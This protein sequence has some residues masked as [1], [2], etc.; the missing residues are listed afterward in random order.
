[1]KSNLGALR[2]L[3]I[4]T[5]LLLVCIPLAAQQ[6]QSQPA[7]RP[8]KIEGD[9]LIRYDNISSLTGSGN[10]DR[11]RAWLRPGFHLAPASW[12]RLEARG[13]FA[14]GT[15]GNRQS[16]LRFDNFHSH[17]ASVDRLYL[18]VK[19]RGFEFGAGKFAMPLQV[20]EMI[21]DHD[22]QPSGLY[23]G[24]RRAGISLTGGVFY[25]SH[26]H[27]DRST[28]AGGQ[29]AFRHN[30]QG[31]WT[32]LATAG[33]M[34]FNALEQFQ[35]GMARQ[36][37]TM[38]EGGRLRYQSDFE[39]ANGQFRIEHHG[40]A[41]WPLAI[42]STL[43]YNFGADDKGS[44]VEMY[45]EVGKLEKRGD[46]RFTVALQTVGQDAVVGAFTSDDWWYHSDH[47]GTRVTAA[48]SLHP[49]IYLSVNGLVQR[50]SGAADWV[51]RFQVDLVARR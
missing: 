33:Y 38:L 7:R 34:A 44:A 13:S 26:I 50:R 45:A 47:R 14:L 35:P 2:A 17:D 9:L 19:G 3:V 18:A 37:R 29:I 48:Y 5:A 8:F 28:I 4:V 10:I 20:S 21:W 27:H 31:A 51:R 43:V 24:Y 12:A 42:E 39:L 46:L 49:R 41:R 36:N 25:R 1:M 32:A 40:S 11:V 23:A 15:D 22:I 6:T 30:S 16:I